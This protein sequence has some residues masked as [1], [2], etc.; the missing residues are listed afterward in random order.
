LVQANEGIIPSNEG[1]SN[2]GFANTGNLNDFANS[3]QESENLTARAKDN[4]F[5]IA[6]A[7]S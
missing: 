6:K 3:L 1:D 5:K 2:N 4:Q 7:R